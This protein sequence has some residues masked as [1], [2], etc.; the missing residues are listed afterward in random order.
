MT[1]FPPPN[2]VGVPH[3][4]EPAESEDDLDSI[5]QRQLTKRTVNDMFAMEVTSP[6]LLR[7]TRAY[8]ALRCCGRAL[9]HSFSGDLHHKSFPT[10]S[11]D[12][13]WSHSWHGSSWQKILLLMVVYNGQ[14]ALIAGHIAAVLGMSLFYLELLPSYSRHYQLV[15]DVGANYYYGPWGLAFGCATTFCMLFVWHPRSKIFL[16]RICIHQVNEDRKKQGIFSLGGFLRRSGSMLVMWDSTYPTRLW[17]VFELAAFL[18]SHG[19]E[20]PLLIRPTILGP[21]AIALFVCVGV[22]FVGQTLVL[23]EQGAERP[24]QRLASFLI[25][26][27]PG[28]SVYQ[29]CQ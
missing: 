6:E 1:A 20:S 5:G 19:D 27:V 7:A 14:A 4:D 8:S 2:P 12:C 3:Q 21:T 24:L 15:G 10:D 17:T 18:K 29:V 26:S 22:S 13:F 9:H 23:A 25:L 11:F 28:R 16:D